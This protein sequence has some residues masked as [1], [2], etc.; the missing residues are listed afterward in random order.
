MADESDTDEVVAMV[1][2]KFYETYLYLASVNAYCND[3]KH[4]SSTD[5]LDE[6][7]G[8]NAFYAS[9][10]FKSYDEMIDFLKTIMSEELI[11]KNTLISKDL[12]R[13]ENDKLYCADLG[14]G[15]V[16]N[17]GVYSVTVNN[18]SDNEILAEATMELAPLSNDES[19]YEDYDLVLQLIEDN[20]VIT[21][22]VRK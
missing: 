20:W 9:T 13:E 4:Q 22:Y 18:A 6:D 2:D 3:T 11:N 1:R 10:Q 19:L 5:K 15:G 14:K 7:Y 16:Y 17:Y 21:S 12:Y 8:Y